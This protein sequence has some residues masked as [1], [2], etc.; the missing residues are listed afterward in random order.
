MVCGSFPT[1]PHPHLQGIVKEYGLVEQA[2]SDDEAK[3]QEGKVEHVNCP[4]SSPPPFSLLLPSIV[5]FYKQAPH[6]SLCLWI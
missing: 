6:A 4:L 1:V 3:G 2:D 5:R